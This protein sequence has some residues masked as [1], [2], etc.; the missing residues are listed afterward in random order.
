[1]DYILKFL[2]NLVF[3]INEI[4]KILIVNLDLN[5]VLKMIGYDFFVY[6]FSLMLSAKFIGFKKILKN[7][8][9]EKK[10][11]QQIDDYEKK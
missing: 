2:H 8:L 5:K 7:S 6:L 11:K 3:D 9:K 10:L 1:M 4:S